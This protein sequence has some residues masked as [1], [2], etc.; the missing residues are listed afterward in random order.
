MDSKLFQNNVYACRWL[1]YP[2]IANNFTPGFFAASIT[3]YGSMQEAH[4]VATESDLF[5]YPMWVPVIGINQYLSIISYIILD[6]VYDEVI[7]KKKCI[8][9]FVC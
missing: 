8:F 6:E 2:T 1:H 4:V 3:N 5:F 7:L 9:R